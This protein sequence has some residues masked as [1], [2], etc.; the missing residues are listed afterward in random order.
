LLSKPGGRRR[1]PPTVSSQQPLASIPC[2]AVARVP[3]PRSV[4]AAPP[5]Y[6]MNQPAMQ[7]QPSHVANSIHSRMNQPAGESSFVMQGQLS[8]VTNSVHSRVQYPE[9]CQ[10]YVPSGYHSLTATPNLYQHPTVSFNYTPYSAIDQCQPSPSLPHIQS[11][12]SSQV[13]Y[14]PPSSGYPAVQSHG[15][16]HQQGQG[17]GYNCRQQLFPPK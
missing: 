8:H 15:F 7:E 5:N 12:P 16:G 13:N 11:H 10:A 2:P 6:Q 4:Q 14:T 17:Q 1:R 9:T 3:Q